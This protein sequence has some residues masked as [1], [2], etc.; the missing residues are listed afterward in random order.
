MRMVP[1][2]SQVCFSSRQG[3]QVGDDLPF[4]VIPDS[5]HCQGFGPGVLRLL[6]SSLTEQLRSDRR[7]HEQRPVSD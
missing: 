2:S 4:N 1:I 5:K 3:S 7:T 6:V